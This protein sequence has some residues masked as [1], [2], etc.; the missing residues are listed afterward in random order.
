MAYSKRVWTDSPLEMVTYEDFN[1]IEEGIEANDL[2]I[3]KQKD[4][5]K[6]G[7]LA[8]QIADIKDETQEGSLAQKIADAEEQINVLT[9]VQEVELLNGWQH[10]NGTKNVKV[11]RTGNIVSITDLF[12]S[13]VKKEPTVIFQLPEGTRPLKGFDLSVESYTDSPWSP[14]KMTFS[15]STSGSVT[16][17]GTPTD[18]YVRFVISFACDWEG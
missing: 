10:T 8:K 13:G 17:R 5:T 11:V 7:S 3:S 4:A 1:R 16:V 18:T 15:F 14:N 2:E 12:Q 6:E 9:E